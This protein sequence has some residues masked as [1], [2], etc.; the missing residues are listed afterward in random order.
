MDLSI[1]REKSFIALMII[2]FFL[3]YVFAVNSAASVYLAEDFELNAAALAKMFGWF[4]V[5]SIGTLLLTRAVDTMGRRKL[6]IISLVITM[7]LALL[8]VLTSNLPTFII[9]QTVLF[10]FAGVVEAAS[11]VMI[12]ECMPTKKRAQAHAAAVVMVLLGAGAALI[13]ITVLSEMSVSDVWRWAW[14]FSIVIPLITLRFIIRSLTETESFTS[15]TE[16]RKN[17]HWL[18][19]FQGEYQSRTLAVLLAHWLSIVAMIAAMTYPFYYLAEVH[20]M[21]QLYVT[22]IIIG[23]GLFGLVGPLL[24]SRISDQFGRRISFMV[25]SILVMLAGLFFYSITE[26]GLSTVLALFL[27]YAALS[28]F[29]GAMIV[30]V[31]SITTELFPTRFRATV[32]GLL[33]V[34]AATAAAFSHFSAAYLIEYVGSLA[35]AVSLLCLLRVPAAF[36]YLFVPET[37]GMELSEAA[38]ES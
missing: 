35:I 2:T 22:A 38:L 10:L 25:F 30:T 19:L 16:Q 20:Q 28:A 24:G 3:G 26:N 23:G 36:I 6:L 8:S 18:E 31:R 5:G 32:Q 29:E 15:D 1:F 13:C 27:A 12:T 4:S 7:L 14:A 17:S 33:A 21:D 11:V 37:K 9:L 34:V